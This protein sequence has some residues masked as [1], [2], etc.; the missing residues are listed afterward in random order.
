MFPEWVIDVL[1][2]TAV[3]LAIW[4]LAVLFPFRRMAAN[5]EF[6]WDL[7][8]VVAVSLFG[9]AAASGLFLMFS[10][11]MDMIS[12]WYSLI[13]QWSSMSLLIAYVLFADFSAYWAHRLLHSRFLWHSHAFHH[14]P[15][16]LYVLSG[17]RAS[18]VHI[19]VLFAGPT[20]GLVLFP[21]YESP[22]AFLLATWLQILNQHI[23]H[24]NLKIPFARQLEYLLVTPRFHFVH[25]SADRK[26]SDNNFGFVF[27]I[28]DRL[29]GTYVTPESV[30]EQQ[31][32][33]LAYAN[34]N[35][36]LLIGLLPPKQP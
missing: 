15:R 30:G 11:F 35:L 17:S 9:V 13:G 16:H 4:G 18:F 2:E 36:R 20:L 23:I 34:S 6:R 3:A 27:S 10:L 24:S 12:Q 25:H 5:N 1:S 21:V 33:G 32:L 19:V 29:F 22:T 31:P 14:S 7:I 26:I 8:A 28:W